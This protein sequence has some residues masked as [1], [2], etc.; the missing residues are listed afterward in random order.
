MVTLVGLVVVWQ[1]EL[2]FRLAGIALGLLAGWSAVRV[3]TGMSA[4][5]RMTGQRPR[6]RGAVVLGLALTSVVTLILISEAVYYPVISD[7]EQCQAQAQT[8]TA[9]NACQQE[10]KNRFQRLKDQLDK[11]AK[12]N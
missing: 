10:F 4:H 2:P 8:Q 3:L 1:L 6:S 9:Q 11:K 12:E 7:F 5:T